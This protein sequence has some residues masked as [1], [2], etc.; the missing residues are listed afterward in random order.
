MA[1]PPAHAADPAPTPAELLAKCN[2][3]TDKCIF[4][5]SGPMRNVAGETHQVGDSDYNCTRLS[6]RSGI[7]W[8]DTVEESNSLG[9]ATTAGVGTGSEG[10]GWK[11][12]L[13]FS[14]TIS[15]EH[16][17]RHATT[18]SATTFVDVRPNSVGWVTRTPDLQKVKGTYELIFGKRFRGH[19]Y[20]YVPFEATSPLDTSTVAQHTRPMTKDERA[21]HC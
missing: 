18:T 13:S 3:G 4:H 21:K 19:Y 14:V 2:N 16:Q 6:Q 7:G 1:T 17:W 5:P 20:W 8:S 11:V 12:S 15:Y 9:L 10:P